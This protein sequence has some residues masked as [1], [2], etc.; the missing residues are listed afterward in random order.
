VLVV[1]PAKVQLVYGGG[2]R[3]NGKARAKLARLAA[4]IEAAVALQHRS[5]GLLA[6]LA[7]IRSRDV[8]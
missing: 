1:T 7:L 3:K 8:L 2:D 4:S 5:Q 6:H